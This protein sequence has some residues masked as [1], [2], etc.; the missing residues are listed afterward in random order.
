M[1]I[2]SKWKPKKN[3]QSIFCI[4]IFSCGVCFSLFLT[5]LINNGI[6]NS[7]YKNAIFNIYNNIPDGNYL[8]VRDDYSMLSSIQNSFDKNDLLLANEYSR[9]NKDKDALSVR[10]KSEGV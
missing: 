6:L 9:I 1:F 5:Y 8:Q 10:D 2:I 4:I 7:F 3:M